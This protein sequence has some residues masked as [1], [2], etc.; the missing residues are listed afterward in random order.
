MGRYIVLCDHDLLWDK[1]FKEEFDKEDIFI[2][3]IDEVEDIESKAFAGGHADIIV[4]SL[5][6]FYNYME[7][8]E[9]GNIYGCL[10]KK[11]IAVCVI[12]DEYSVSDELNVLRAGCFDYQLRTK[13]IEVIAQRIRN[14]FSDADK[15]KSVYID[16][17]T[18]EIYAG[19]EP[20]NFTRHEKAVFNILLK[21]EGEIVEKNVILK[22]VWGIEFNGSIRVIDT[23][24]KQLRKKVSDYNIEI[25][26]YY[27]RG[28]SL[29]F[30]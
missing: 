1:R 21:N 17:K 28:I 25:N 22:E 7:Y 15:G 20:I 16:D 8:E 9:T 14:R 23:V 11:N 24:V 18:C 19:G 13:P 30:K 2:S 12:A 29:C 5:D 26:T 6:E 10:L 4:C 3:Q 27:G